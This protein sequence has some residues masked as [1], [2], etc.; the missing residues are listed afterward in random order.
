MAVTIRQRIQA[1]AES[2]GQ[3]GGQIRELDDAI[4]QISNL[5]LDRNYD[6][7][8]EDNNPKREYT[9]AEVR[10]G[11]QCKKIVNKK[12]LTA[13]TIRKIICEL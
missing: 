3:L 8:P 11:S 12:D 4:A 5:R 9:R 13:C 1:R 7:K 6:P 2:G 10:N